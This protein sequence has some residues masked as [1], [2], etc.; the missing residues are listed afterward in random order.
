MILQTPDCPYFRKKNI[1]WFWSS[2]ISLI[3]PFWGV[4]LTIISNNDY[5]EF[6][7]SI[8][9]AHYRLGVTT[10]A[11]DGKSEFQKLIEKDLENPWEIAREIFELARPC[12]CD[13]PSCI[14]SRTF[15]EEMV[16]I[17]T[18]LSSHEHLLIHPSW[19]YRINGPEDKTNIIIGDVGAM[20]RW[21]EAKESKGNGDLQDRLIVHANHLSVR[22]CGPLR[23]KWIQGSTKNADNTRNGSDKGRDS[24]TR[25]KGSNGNNSGKRIQITI[26]RQKKVVTRAQT[27]HHQARRVPLLTRTTSVW[28]DSLEVVL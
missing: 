10:T 27:I 25:R 13:S 24:V 21:I 1:V 3:H 5:R 26:R 22:I 16:S 19:L 14:C 9:M 6:W 23:A 17:S 11:D 2:Q 28:L 7:I 18:L 20:D 12:A 4:L 8:K 15:P